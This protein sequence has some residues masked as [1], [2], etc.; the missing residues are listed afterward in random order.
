MANLRDSMNP[1][2]R[3]LHNE[4]LLNIIAE[5][6]APL[7]EKTIK[8]FVFH[9][10]KSAKKKSMLIGNLRNEYTSSVFLSAFNIV[11]GV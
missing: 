8:N 7:T 9:K 1:F 6:A 11:C 4:Y 3:N 10:D 2:T 5:K